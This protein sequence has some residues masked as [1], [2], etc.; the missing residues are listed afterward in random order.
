MS[1]ARLDRLLFMA[2]LAWIGVLLILWQMSGLHFLVSHRFALWFHAGTW[3]ITLMSCCSF[4]WS[5]AIAAPA[6]RL[7]LIALAMAVQVAVSFAIRQHTTDIF[8]R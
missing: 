5:T 2:S 6:S 4:A 8:P 1:L 7:W 3:A